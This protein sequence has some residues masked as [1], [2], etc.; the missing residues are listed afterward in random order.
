MLDLKA[1]NSVKREIFLDP[2][3]GS[4]I[5]PCDVSRGFRIQ[6]YLELFRIQNYLG[7]RMQNYLGFRIYLELFRIQKAQPHRH[8]FYFVFF[9]SQPPSPPKKIWKLI[10]SN[11]EKK[12]KGE[13]FGGPIISFIP[14]KEQQL[15][16][17]LK[18]QL[19]PSWSFGRKSGSFS[20]PGLKC[21]ILQ[22]RWVCGFSP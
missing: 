10:W 15:L 3:P 14:T 19:F 12:K 20:S 22:P 21:P 5:S 8:S 2:N 11:V 18:S 1:Q 9:L 17:K 7:C 13:Y 6:N 16:E 4:Q